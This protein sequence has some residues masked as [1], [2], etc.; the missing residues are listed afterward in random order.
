MNTLLVPVDFSKAAR[1]ALDAAQKLAEGPDAL[2]ILL[3]V[4]DSSQLDFA[5]GLGLAPR[6]ALVKRLRAE[7][8]RELKA[9]GKRMKTKSENVIS[10]GV[11]FLEILK[12][13]EDFEV[14]G[15][16]MGKFGRSAH[17]QKFL[18]GTTAEKVVRG[19]DCPVL[20]VP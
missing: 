6:P 17:W 8:D 19:A 2:V 3:H 10:V 11:P 15:I 14:D 7:A 5:A 9:I 4:I 12:K 16:V 13:A 18:F 20:V 1:R